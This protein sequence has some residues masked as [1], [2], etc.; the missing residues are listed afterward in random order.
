MRVL[1]AL[2]WLPVLQAAKPT[3]PEKTMKS[4]VER[5]DFSPYGLMHPRHR[6]KTPIRKLLPSTSLEMSKEEYEALKQKE[7]MKYEM[8]KRLLETEMARKYEGAHVPEPICGRRSSYID[9][10]GI[11][12]NKPGCKLQGEKYD[13]SN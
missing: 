3:P 7:I 1:Q 10:D 6:P 12:R 2:G 13:F 5:Y 4:G 11:V 9:W 8:E